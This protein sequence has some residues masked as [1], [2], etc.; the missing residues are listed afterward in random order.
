MFEI[1]VTTIIGMSLIYYGYKHKI[2]NQSK[3][4][5]KRLEIEHTKLRIKEKALDREIENERKDT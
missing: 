5:M 4:E 2:S 3:L 1:C